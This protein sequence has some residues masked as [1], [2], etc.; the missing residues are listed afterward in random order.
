MVLMCSRMF[1]KESDEVE[2]YVGGLLD[3]I[4]GSVMVSKPKTMQDAIE[5]ATE[6]MD[7]KIRTFADRANQRVVTCF[8]CEAQGHFK[9]DCPKLKNSNRRNQAGNGGATARA[10]VVENIRNSGCQCSYGSLIDIVPT[11]LDHDYD[12]E[13]ADEKIIRVNTI[14]S[15]TGKGYRGIGLWG[16][17]RGELGKVLGRCISESKSLLTSC[18]WEVGRVWFNKQLPFVIDTRM[19]TKEEGLGLYSCVMSNGRTQDEEKV[20]NLLY[21]II[22]RTESSSTMTDSSMNNL[23]HLAGRLAPSYVLSRTT[24]VALQLQRDGQADDKTSILE[25]VDMADLQCM[26][27][28]VQPHVSDHMDQIKNMIAKVPDVVYD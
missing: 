24:D 3:I 1:P 7:Q 14:D 28:T 8:E 15:L 25:I 4:Q 19:R 17:V 27:P 21:P 16:K 12:V 22:K 13:L 18:K 5:F 26:P 11:A 20:Y 10:Y 23:V 2:K 6:L 9:R